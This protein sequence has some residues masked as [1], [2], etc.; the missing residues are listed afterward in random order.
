MTKVN[1]FYN[2]MIATPDTFAC[3]VD[4]VGPS[5][6]LT[7]LNTTLPYW[8][9]TDEESVHWIGDNRTAEGRAFLT[10]RS[11]LTHV[12]RISKLLLVAQGV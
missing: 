12:G 4:L 8:K 1:L 11:P 3:G 10:E 6:M 5:S 7:F 2:G 9:P